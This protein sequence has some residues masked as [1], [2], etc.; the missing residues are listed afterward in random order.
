MVQYPQLFIEGTVLHFWGLSPQPF[1]QWSFYS[2]VTSLLVV[3]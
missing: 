3:V 1:C 2:A